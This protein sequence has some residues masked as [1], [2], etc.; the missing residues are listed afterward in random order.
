MPAPTPSKLR[1]VETGAEERTLGDICRRPS[2]FGV[3]VGR[4]G[5]GGSN[6]STSSPRRGGGMTRMLRSGGVRTGFTCVSGGGPAYGAT[7]NDPLRTGP[8]GM[9]GAADLGFFALKRPGD[10]QA[11]ALPVVMMQKITKTADRKRRETGIESD[12]LVG[13]LAH[14]RPLP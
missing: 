14:D 1:P 11:S 3:S 5:C 10:G 13:P 12:P 9:D 4:F 6:F 8:A 2:S 7:G